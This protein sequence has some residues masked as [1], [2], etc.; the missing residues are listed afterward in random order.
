MIIKSLVAQSLIIGVLGTAIGW[1]LLWVTVVM[2]PATMPFTID[3]V[4]FSEYSVGIIFAAL[5]G[6]IFSFKTVV[7]VD[8]ITAI[9]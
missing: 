1:L 9:Q 8:P 2:L 5:L 4:R 3:Y 6:G 7:K